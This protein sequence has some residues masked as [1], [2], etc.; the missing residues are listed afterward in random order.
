MPNFPLT[1]RNGPWGARGAAKDISAAPRRLESITIVSGSAIDSLKFSYTSEDGQ[2]HTYGPWGGK[3]GYEE[4]TI[5]LESDESIIE[6]SGTTGNFDDKVVV[7][8]LK[9]VTNLGH[10]FGPYGEQINGD[11]PFSSNGTVVGFHGSSRAYL[12]SIGTYTLIHQPQP[13]LNGPWGGQGG[14]SKMITKVPQRLERITIR[15]GWIIDSIEFTYISQ[16]GQRHNEGPWGGNGGDKQPE[17]CLQ[18]NEFIT[19][20][21]GTHGTFYHHYVVRSLKF[22]TNFGRTHGPYGGHETNGSTS[23]SSYGTVVGFQGRS[24]I[25]LDS[26]GTYTV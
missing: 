8:S 3:G 7:K 5:N 25:Y 21:S 19:E 4:E 2:S 6:V 12:D 20:V 9:F 10:T 14:N 23:F 24:G 16:D 18:P 1:K 15:S 26:I 13:T 17:I 22:V 11:N